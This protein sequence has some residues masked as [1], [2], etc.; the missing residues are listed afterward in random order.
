MTA[1]PGDGFYHAPV[2][3]LPY[4]APYGPVELVRQVRRDPLSFFARLCEEGGDAVR[5]NLAG[6]KVLM[7][8]KAEHIKHVLQ[9]NHANYHKSKFYKPLYP[10]LG[11]G[12][13]TAEG[14]A[15]LR[16]RR[17]AVKGHPQLPVAVQAAEPVRLATPEPLATRHDRL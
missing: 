5:F 7:L 13:F 16:Q 11:K 17:L 8:N 3:N 1:L 12:I 2:G 6:N 15:W 14:D 10:I 4:D 9:D